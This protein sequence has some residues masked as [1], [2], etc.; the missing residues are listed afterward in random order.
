MNHN[1][2][3]ALYILSSTNTFGG[4]SKA[5]T[6]LLSGL[7]AKGVSPTVVLPGKDGLYEELAKIGA[8]VYY[9]PVRPNVYPK[10]KGLK[11]IILYIP[12]LLYWHALN[13]YSRKRIA[14]YIKDKHID[15]IHTNVSIMD[16]GHDIA[17]RFGIPHIFHIREYADKDFNI[18]Y[19]PGKE[20]YH[21]MF[22]SS[23]NYSIC[24]TKDIR[25]HHKLE[26]T[27]SSRVIYDGVCPIGSVKTNNAKERYFLYAGRIQ[28]GKG[29]LPLV[30]AYTEY[31]SKSGGPNPVPLHVAGETTDAAY[32]QNIRQHIAAHGINDHIKFLGPRTDVASLMQHALAIIIPSEFEGFGFCMTEA[33]FNGCLVV[34]HNTGGTKEQFDNGVELSGKEIG[35]RYDTEGQL[36]DHL[37]KI[38]GSQQQ[39][40]QET[41]ATAADVVSRL[42]SVEVSVNNVYNYYIE[43][44][45][46]EN[47]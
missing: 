2:I 25:K 6:S 4:A 30:K 16:I 14:G 8:T 10:C 27:P 47:N 37:C 15:I 44:L 36:T 7:M 38:A 20:A 32:C 13:A 31:V 34:G 41:I 1:K 24:I 23:G 17:K 26:S 3:N 19:F 33:M 5:I 22:T 9:A 18:K 35:L 40:F 29:L 46:N 39:V 43:I 42:Y 28:P 21:R 12:R 45:N 11:N